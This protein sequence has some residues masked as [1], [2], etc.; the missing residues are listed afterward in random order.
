MHHIFSRFNDYNISPF[1]NASAFYNGVLNND[2]LITQTGYLPEEVAIFNNQI[3]L[4]LAQNQEGVAV[5][6]IELLS[7]LLEGYITI[8]DSKNKSFKVVPNS[9]LIN[10]IIL[11]Y[12]GLLTIQEEQLTA[13]VR[14][15]EI[16][17]YPNTLQVIND[18][19]TEILNLPILSGIKSSYQPLGGDEESFENYIQS[20]AG[21]YDKRFCYNHTFYVIYRMVDEAEIKMEVQIAINQLTL[22]NSYIKALGEI[23]PIKAESL[24]IL[25][26]LMQINRVLSL[27]C[28]TGIIAGQKASYQEEEKQQALETLLKAE[29]E[30]DRILFEEV[31]KPIINQF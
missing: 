8:T 6:T 16:L 2:S 29:E 15:D 26:T 31:I 24:P 12:S 1:R 11:I 4:I 27:D 10:H 7:F 18:L 23:I 14:V 30:S 28:L 21:I 19:R 13:Q 22:E 9:E 25:K 5:A 20:K 17:D 3:S